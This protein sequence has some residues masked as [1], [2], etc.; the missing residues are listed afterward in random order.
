MGAPALLLNLD[1]D[2]SRTGLPPWKGE[3]GKS[4]DDS[5]P[6]FLE[7]KVKSSR[8]FPELEGVFGTIWPS[9]LMVAGLKCHALLTALNNKL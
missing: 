8:K 6:N 7:H 5:E 2:F 4:H 3:A 1:D 9:P